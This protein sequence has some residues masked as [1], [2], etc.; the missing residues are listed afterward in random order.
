MGD[1]AARP[2]QKLS[3]FIAEGIQ[4]IALDIQHAQNVPV[5]I[6]HWDNDL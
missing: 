4:L 3:I 2:L 5:L 6:P 1:Q